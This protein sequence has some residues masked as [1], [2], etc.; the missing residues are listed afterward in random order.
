MSDEDELERRLAALRQGYAHKLRARLEAL[1][2]L[3]ARAKGGDR[4]AFEAAVSEAHKLHGTA[5]SY[6]FAQ[7]S[8]VLGEVEVQLKRIASVGAKSPA[9]WDVVFEALRASLH[10]PSLA[11]RDGDA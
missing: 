1:V 8:S 2:E 5:G 3:A 11:P 4:E 7:A 6:G 9:D 10:D